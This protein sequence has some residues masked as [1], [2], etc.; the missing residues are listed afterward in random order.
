MSAEALK[1]C[2]LWT[3]ILKDKNLD[4]AISDNKAT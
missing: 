2:I 1:T 4:A 3:P